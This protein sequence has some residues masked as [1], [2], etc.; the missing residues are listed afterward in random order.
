MRMAGSSVGVVGG[1]V[2]GMTVALRLAQQGHQV[3]LLESAPSIGGL[4]SPEAI[5]D[6]SWDRFYHVMLLSDRHL[7]GL[8]DELGLTQNA[9]WRETR[10]GF[11]GDGRFHEMSSSLDFAR[12][13]L[14]TLAE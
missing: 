7:V 10:T 3:T 11:Y 8:L 14:L 9:H 6:A 5:G 1:G 12:F 2:L 13:P 4:A